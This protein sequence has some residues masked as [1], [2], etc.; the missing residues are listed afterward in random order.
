M[1][2]LSALRLYGHIVYISRLVGLQR[3]QKTELLK[4]YDEVSIWICLFMYLF[5]MG[6]VMVSDCGEAVIFYSTSFHF[7]PKV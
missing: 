6:T 4:E 3:R 7:F 5:S 1:I 2:L